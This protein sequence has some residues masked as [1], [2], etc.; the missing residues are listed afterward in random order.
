[1][2]RFRFTNLGAE[3]QR[4]E[5][6]FRYSNESNSSGDR[7]NL[8]E[9]LLY[10]EWGNEKVLR[11][12]YETSMAA[13]AL[14]REIAFSKDLGPGESCELVLEVPF[15]ALSSEEDLNHLAALDYDPWY[16]RTRK[17]R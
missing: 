1:M 5:L 15:V 8:Q 17:T 14:E 3:S 2:V 13:S 10:S 11:A 9:N 16:L 4:A 12:R 6:P 7:L